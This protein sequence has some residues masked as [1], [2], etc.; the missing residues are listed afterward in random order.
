MFPETYSVPGRLVP[1][2]GI[3]YKERGYIQSCAFM[4][5]NR[6]NGTNIQKR[7]EI[8]FFFVKLLYQE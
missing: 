3:L 1:A 4:L 6:V 5:N 7:C 8:L 2:I